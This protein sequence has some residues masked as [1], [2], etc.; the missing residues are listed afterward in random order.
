MDLSLKE[1]LIFFVVKQ[2][3][4]ALASMY[5]VRPHTC[6]NSAGEIEINDSVGERAREQS[7]GYDDTSD[8]N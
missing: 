2:T 4:N 7:R 6:Y 5:S 3:L 8:D 1:D